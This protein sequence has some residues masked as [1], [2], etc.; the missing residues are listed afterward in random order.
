[1][2]ILRP[3]HPFVLIALSFLGLAG[4]QQVDTSDIPVSGPIVVPTKI[5]VAEISPTATPI[6]TQAA[7]VVVPTSVIEAEPTI[8]SEP[9][10]TAMPDPTPEP[11]A[12]PTSESE[13][14]QATAQLPG[15]ELFSFAADEPS[16]YTVDDDV[17]GGVSSSDVAI[18]E[19]NQL[20]FSGTMSLDNNG[21]FSSVRSNWQLT[22][23]SGNDGVLLRVLGDGKVYRLRIR[24]DAA[25]RG[26]SYNALFQTEADK[27]TTV[28]IPFAEMVPTYRGFIMDV[29]PLDPATIGSFGFML[30][31]KQPGEFEL[32]VD[33]V[34]AVSSA[35]IKVLDRTQD[36]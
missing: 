19:S 26:I 1:M 33:W 5:E 4:C 10:E 35:D 32:V 2:K 6:P 36:G 23:L 24:T 14:T 12:T 17:M 8:V 22:D 15:T 13:T 7:V 25:G 27:W 34:R 18:I 3:F 30:S 31:D 28:F 11:E 16:W 20:Y 21:G 29:G 9:T